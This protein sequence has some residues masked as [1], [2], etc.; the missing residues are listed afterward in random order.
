[1]SLLTKIRARAGAGLARTRIGAVVV[2][3]APDGVTAEARALAAALPADPEHELVVADL[4]SVS[5]VEVWKAFVAAL[6]RGNR[7]LRVVPGQAPHEI[8]PYVWQWLA[9]RVGRGVLA[10]YGRTHHVAGLL[11]VHSVEHSGWVWFRRNQ[12][13]AWKGKRFP[14][15]DWDSIEVGQARTAGF[16]GVAEPLPA[17]MWLRPD[18]GDDVLTTGRA[19]LTRTLPCLPGA[20]TIV[21][22]AHDVADIELTDIAAF[23]RTLP[24]DTA[25]RARFV[26]FGGV[27]LPDGVPFGQALAD[28]LDAEVCCY[29]GIPAGTQDAL[30]VLALRQ[31][32]SLGRSAFAQAFTHR[33]R[34]AP[35]LSIYRAPFDGLA[36]VSP[37]I[38][39]YA[40][41]VVLEIVRAGLW[42]RP[43]EQVTDPAGV[44]TVP[45][46]PAHNL[47]LYDATDPTQAERLR[48]MA[49]SVLDRLDPANRPATRLMPTTALSETAL[50]GLSRTTARSDTARSDTARSDTARTD[51]ARMD[52]ARTEVARTEVVR[53]GNQPVSSVPAAVEPVPIPEPEPEADTQ[54]EDP[55]A[56]TD[57]PWLS[58]LM[59]TM[60]MPVPVRQADPV[61]E[62]RDDRAS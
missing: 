52:A 41:N 31:D 60:S 33:P 43:A 8:A 37:G 42:I 26:R 44:R 36:E 48:E 24:P 6:P 16:R 25:A 14:R 17:G 11:F 62:R 40:P 58:R 49:E 18:V 29:T 28:V 3:H 56:E 10:P 57:L 30:E 54:S 1:M 38:Y 59:E 4:P 2:V 53:P 21:L 45:L 22:G 34:T 23:M 12:A 39:W 20:P 19:R 27:A 50:A 61:M 5:S 9:D 32:G 47:L 55:A 13:P 51:A 7:P 35:R 46:D 15:P